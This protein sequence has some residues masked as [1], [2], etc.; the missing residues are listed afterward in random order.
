LVDELQYDFIYHE[1]L[2]YYSLTPLVNLFSRFGMSVVGFEEI[3]THS[4]S[5]RVTIQ[6]TENKVVGEVNTRLEAEKVEGLTS[7]SH[8]VDFG[9]KIKTHIQNLTS[10]IK[11][12]KQQGHSIAGY[13]ASGRA[14]ML[15]NMC[16]LTVQEIDYIVDESP[17]RINRYIPGV[18]IPTV[19]ID[20][21]QKFPPSHV[22]ILA[23]NYSDMIKSKLQ[24]LGFTH[25]NYITPFTK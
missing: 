8:F 1:H 2:Y 19:S 12:L 17:E 11:A 10:Q 6:N 9:D 20:H 4:G 24:T 25:L 21:L 18:N 7:Y 23:W 3:E 22:F 13:G 15:L 14:N 16:N 5:I